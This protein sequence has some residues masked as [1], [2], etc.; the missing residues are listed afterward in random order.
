MSEAKKSLL[1]F[2]PVYLLVSI[3]TCQA[4][5]ITSLLK[6]TPKVVDYVE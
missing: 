2:V 5:Q 6:Q 4:L 1:F 3:A